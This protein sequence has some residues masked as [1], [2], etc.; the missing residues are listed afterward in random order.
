M[1]ERKEK[2]EEERVQRSKDLDLMKELEEAVSEWVQIRVQL[3]EPGMSKD[4]KEG[5]LR[6]I[7]AI[8]P[9]Y[10]TGASI[11]SGIKSIKKKA[12]KIRHY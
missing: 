3:R 9:K 4:E 7:R 5:L 6:R 11:P 10:G 8:D 12:R 1:A 2:Q